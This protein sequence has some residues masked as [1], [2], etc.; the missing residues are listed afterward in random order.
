M[1]YADV[2]AQ[3]DEEFRRD[4][5]AWRRRRM[6]VFTGPHGWL[7]LRQL[8]WLEDGSVTRV[9]GFPGTWAAEA[10]VVVYTPDTG[11][12]VVNRGAELTGSLRIEAPG[13]GDM[14]LENIDFGE[15]RAELIKRTGASLS[16][17]VRLRDP[18]AP[19]RTHFSGARYFPVNRAWVLPARFEPAATSRDIHVE[20]DLRDFSVECVMGTL[21]MSFEGRDY[22]LVVLQDHNDDTGERTRDTRGRLHYVDNRWGTDRIGVVRFRDATSGVETYGG[23]RRITVPLDDPES[24]DHVDFNRAVSPSCA[25]NVYCTCPFAPS[26]NVLPFPVA[27]GEMTPRIYENPLEGKGTGTGVLCGLWELSEDMTDSPRED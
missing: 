24:I 14:S 18:H 22:P 7:S 13:Q 4:V 20:A 2:L 21:T 3:S 19:N 16:F 15:L 26:G 1:R 12:S 10:N 11:S 6:E 27:A 23:G 9:P 5:Q 25:Y 8:T 17:A